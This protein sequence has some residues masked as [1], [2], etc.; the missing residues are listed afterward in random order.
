MP[1]LRDRIGKVFYGQ[2]LE[3]LERATEAVVDHLQR[4]PITT[5]PEQLIQRLGEVDS[6]YIDLLV[7]QIRER[8][9]FLDTTSEA[10]RLGVV[11]ECRNLYV[12]DVVTQSIIDLWTDYGFSTS[13]GVEC[14]DEAAQAA[15]DEFWTAKRNTQ[16]LG[17]RDV[18]QLSADLLNDGEFYF[19][20]FISKAD[21]K[22]TVR[23]V[24]TEQIIEFIR[25]PDDART[26]LYFKRQYTPVASA[27][28]VD[29]YYR[30]W[31]VDDNQAAK[32]ELPEG[33]GKAEEMRG[34]V[35]TGTDV[36]MMQVSHRER[37]GRG[38]PLMTA[39]AAWSRAYRNFLQDRASVAR[40]VAM[41]VDK[42]K[43]Q[44]SSRAVDNIAARL[45]SAL[46]SGSGAYDTNPPPVA[47]STWIQNQ[48][49]D[50]ERMPLNTGAGD[51]EKDGAPLLAQAGLAGRI[52]PHYLG[53][54][55]AFRLATATSM[56]VPVLKAFSRYQKFWASVWHDIAEIVLEKYQQYSGVI[57]ASAE[58]D[59]S[60]QSIVQT[61]IKEVALMLDSIVSAST[62]GVID[63]QTARIAATA[64][65]KA[66]VVTLGISD[67]SEFE[68]AEAAELG[69]AAIDRYR[70]SLRAEVYGLWSG[71]TI[72]AEFVNGMQDAIDRNMRLAWHDVLK[73]YG[74]S[75]A[76]MS[77]AEQLELG[78]MIIDEFDHVERFGDYILAN[79]KESGGLFKSLNNRIDMW[80]NRFRDA[81]NR[82]RTMIAGDA[83][84]EWM[85]GA[86][87]EHCASCGSLAGKVKRASQW[88]AFFLAT[89]LRPQSQELACHGYNCLCVLS[90]TTKPLSRGRLP[91]RK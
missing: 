81:T 14:E 46:V 6:H 28:P 32:A 41:Y 74:M 48:A 37:S 55:E 45:Q 68:D 27:A 89:G 56:E 76:D 8:E 70:S 60:T 5:S 59:V 85:L 57:F 16:V 36:L 26:I 44:G 18:Y 83:P 13:I 71:K 54:G 73:E 82:A 75:E 65:T 21:G 50:R 24:P 58:V 42:L 22:T 51:A 86:T 23:T 10:S 19:V 62:S 69:E 63:E 49:L 12:W 90:P 30:N 7:R 40:S 17:E 88:E 87:E 77:S 78:R 31:E 2:K 79:N 33:A 67:G 61:D 66:G 47:G 15:W 39:G 38:W 84:L 3:R 29:I 20:F 34:D 11:R 4:M 9:E 35:G 43:V 64:L 91:V 1:T 25:D 72:Y 53:R 52:F 80:M